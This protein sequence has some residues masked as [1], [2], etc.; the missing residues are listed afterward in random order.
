MVAS[1]PDRRSVSASSNK[2][3]HAEQSVAPLS[4][5]LLQPLH[6][7]RISA[8]H[9]FPALN[10]DGGDD[11]EIGR[12][13]PR[14]STACACTGNPL[15]VGD[16]AARQRHDLDAERRLARQRIVVR[17]QQA[18]GIE[19]VVEAVQ[20]EGHRL[21][22]SQQAH[23]I[24]T[25]RRLHGASPRGTN[26]PILATVALALGRSQSSCFPLDESGGLHRRQ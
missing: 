2:P 4:C 22:D 24:G 18:E 25:S 5:I 11:D 14:R 23:P 15:A 9:P 12:G 8:L 10:H 20:R 19:D 17:A 26:A 6:D 3:E 13:R 1:L 7:L 21:G 16:E